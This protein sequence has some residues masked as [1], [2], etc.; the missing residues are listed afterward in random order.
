MMS[1]RPDDFDASDDEKEEDENI[2]RVT[3]IIRITY[4]SSTFNHDF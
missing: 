2:P 3:N 1:R 4:L